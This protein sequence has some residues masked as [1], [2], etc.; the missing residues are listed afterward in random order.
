M[1]NSK[2]ETD[3]HWDDKALAEL[4]PDIV[5]IEDIYQRQMELQYICENLTRDMVVM[6]AGCGNGYSTNVFR[7]LVSHIDAFDYSQYMIARAKSV[8]GETNNRF[9]QDN[10]L[11]FESPDILMQYDTVI[12]VRVLINL[13]SIEEQRQAL[14]N[15]AVKVRRGGLLILFEG[16]K[17]GFDALDKLRGEAGLMPLE[18]AKIN[19]Y[20]YMGNIIPNLPQKYITLRRYHLGT[21]DFLTRVFYPMLNKPLRNTTFHQKAA[22]LASKCNPMELEQYSRMR[23]FIFK[24]IE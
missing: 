16:F 6:E 17:D 24:R 4:E 15:L 1:R 11:D 9:I 12:C 21:Y 5:N 7:E 22:L 19:H 13:Q 18:P 23:G 3:L 14:S 20:P 8:Y 2:S 10:V